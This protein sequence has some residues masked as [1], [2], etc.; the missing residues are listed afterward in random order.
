[1]LLCTAKT[2][3]AQN[4]SGFKVGDCVEALNF[5]V[6][7]EQ[8]MPGKI[9]KV[10]P[11]TFYSRYSVR[12]DNGV[13]LSGRSPDQVRAHACQSS[14]NGNVP[15]KDLPS[16]NSSAGQAGMNPSQSIEVNNGQLPQGQPQNQGGYGNSQTPPQRNTNGAYPSDIN[17]AWKGTYTCQQGLTNLVLSLSAKSETDVEGIFTFLF[18]D[19]PGTVLLGSYKVKG[20]YDSGNGR[21]ELKGVDWDDKPAGWILVDLSGT[22]TIPR[23]RMAGNVIGPNCTTFQ[24]EKIKF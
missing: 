3:V 19:G 9:I 24:L 2:S 22:V 1:L 5:L 4:T 21:I 15:S 10:D 14:S 13:E 12:F 18:G 17:G 20:T 7:P 23:R 16:S 6:T 11:I 8:W